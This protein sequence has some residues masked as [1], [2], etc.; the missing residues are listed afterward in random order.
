[1]YVRETVL[2]LCETSTL[3]QQL[4]GK[5]LTSRDGAEYDRARRVWNGMIDRRPALIV[6]CAAA[7]DVRA[8]I[9]FAR[10]HGLPI[11]VRSGGHS[12]AGASSIEGGLLIDLSQMKRISIDA[13]AQTAWAQAGLKL[14]ELIAATEA[15]GFVVP[16]GTATDT[17]IAGLTLG[18]GFGWLTGSHGL[19]IDNVL[20]FEVVLADGRIV[21]VDAERNPDLFWALRGGSGNFGVVTAFKYRLSRVGTLL[22]GMVVF[23]FAQA[24]QVLRAYA[25][26]A[27]GLPDNVSGGAAIV[28]TP[29]GQTAVAVIEC[30]SGPLADA[31]RLIAPVRGFGTPVLDTVQPSSYLEMVGLLD[32]ASP[33][34]RNYYEKANALPSLSRDAIDAV[35]EAGAKRTSPFS[36]IVIQ[37]FHGVGTRVAEGATAFAQRFEHHAVMFLSGWETG[38]EGDHVGWARRG[39][40][41]TKPY[42]TEGVYINFLGPEDH[43]RTRASFGPNY[44]RLAAIKQVYD[45]ENIFQR[46]PNVLPAAEPVAA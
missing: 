37:Q 45:P 33:A 28:S 27:A 20:A 1:M 32:P 46:N 13:E 4:R 39:F 24:R 22:G 18:G 5:A 10:R 42:A 14:G 8:A 43:A 3:Q 41:A 17:G 11:A 36:A 15:Q 9:L 23:P 29:D 7:E 19:T 12:T 2:P 40:A 26:Y 31:E 16:V 34:G 38:Q 21:S 35:I 25:D 6:R 44:A 30:A